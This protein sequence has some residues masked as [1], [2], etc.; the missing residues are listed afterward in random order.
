MI[1]PANEPSIW[2]AKRCGYRLRSEAQYRGSKTL[3]FER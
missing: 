2:V 1:D 3:I